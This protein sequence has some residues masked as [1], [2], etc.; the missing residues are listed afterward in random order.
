MV[1]IPF[2]N[3][4]S[5]QKILTLE[6]ALSIAIKNSPEIIKSELNMTIS[7]ENLKA[8]QA[9]SKSKFSLEVA[10]FYYSQNRTYDNFNAVWNTNETKKGYA[11]FIVSQPIVKTD[12]RLTLRNHFEYQD[13]YSQFQDKRTKGYNNNLFLE[14]S[15][16]IF[17]YNKLKMELQRLQM[18]LENSTFNYSLQRLYLEKQVTQFFYNVY[19]IKMALQIAE[20]EYKNQQTSYDIIK[21]KVEAGLTTNAELLQAQLNLANSLSSF[22][23]KKVEL[24]NAKDDFKQYIGSPLSEDFDIQ[25]NID[26]TLIVVDLEKA[27]K[28]GLELRMELKQKEISLQ[29]SK[30]DL[31]VAKSTNKF[32]GNLSLSVGLAGDNPEIPKIYETPT[33]NPQ[34]LLTFTV[35]IWDWGEKRARIKASEASIQIEEINLQS[36]RTSVEIAIRKSNRSLQNLSTQIDIARQNEKNAQLT[37]DINL[38]RYK[39]GDLTSMDL[40][41]YQNQLS[42]A[43]M[44]LANALISYKLELLNMKIQSLWDFESNTN[45]V[46]KS[47]QENLNKQ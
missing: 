37:Y 27:I 30:L 26:F 2:G 10:P 34:V 18:S 9:S 20:E 4:I 6:D 14:F 32:S 39:N 21:S 28:N 11:D 40:G 33:R 44:N 41:R 42:T 8:R 3:T 25:A 15:Q 1:L 7:S 19:Q 46:P 35:P 5:A 16:P 36:E 23:N 24:E 38:E 43:K 12:G 47:L 29:S 17:T 45:F 31:I 13:A 22:Q